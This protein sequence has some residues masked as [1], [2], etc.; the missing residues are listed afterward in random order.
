MHVMASPISMASLQPTR[1]L[2]LQHPHS[3]PWKMQAIAILRTL[4][5]VLAFLVLV[6]GQAR[7]ADPTSSTV[8]ASLRAAIVSATDRARLVERHGPAR[9]ASMMGML[10]ETST[11]DGCTISPPR[12]VARVRDCA[13]PP[14][15]RDLAGAGQTEAD[16]PERPPKRAPHVAT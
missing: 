16:G 5:V 1:H 2:A 15:I 10:C 13:E 12:P 4:A 14:C 8:T 6:P 3:H 7:A 11:D 9:V